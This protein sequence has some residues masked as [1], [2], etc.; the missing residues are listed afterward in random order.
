MLQRK[1]RFVAVSSHG[2]S[3]MEDAS[4]L[5]VLLVVAVWVE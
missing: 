2:C 3:A 4:G 5:E 1:P